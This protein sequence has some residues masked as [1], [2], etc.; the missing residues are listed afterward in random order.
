VVKA[1]GIKAFDNLRARC[2]DD[3]Q[4]R[5]GVDVVGVEQFGACRRVVAHVAFFEDEFPRLQENPHHLAVEAAG[6]GEEKNSMSHEIALRV[7]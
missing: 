7:Y 2:G 6:L 3:Y 5:R 1:V 4:C